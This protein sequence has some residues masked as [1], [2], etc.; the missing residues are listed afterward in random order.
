M[1]NVQYKRFKERVEAIVNKK[2]QALRNKMQEV[3]V[4]HLTLEEM[5]KEVQSG[6]ATL[7]PLDDICNYTDF[8]D[9]FI[10]EGNKKDVQ[11]REKAR[12]AEYEGRVALDVEKERL[13]DAAVF[14]NDDTALNMLAAFDK[15]EV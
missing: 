3:K 15:F 10:F 8:V 12:K 6:K 14:M 7:K 2:Q 9:A 4:K 11:A 5:Y 1:N 13:L